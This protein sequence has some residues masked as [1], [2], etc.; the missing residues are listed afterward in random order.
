L[1]RFYSLLGLVLLKKPLRPNWIE[2]V[3]VASIWGDLFLI[4]IY[5]KP[6]EHN[7]PAQKIANART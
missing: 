7:I 4:L 6:I 2:L 1:V 3:I 5:V